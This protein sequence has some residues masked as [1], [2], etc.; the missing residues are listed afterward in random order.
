MGAVF[1]CTS[2]LLFRH[3][4]LIAR[5]SHICPEKQVLTNS[6]VWKDAASKAA[7][8][9]QLGLIIDRFDSSFKSFIYGKKL[10]TVPFSDSDF[11]YHCF[12]EFT[13]YFCLAEGLDKDAFEEAY[14]Q[15]HMFVFPLPLNLAYY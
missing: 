14:Y 5:Y 2:L 6:T 4:S 9:T 3:D 11:P 10:Y 7:A 15:F 1:I 12:L 8:A 13:S